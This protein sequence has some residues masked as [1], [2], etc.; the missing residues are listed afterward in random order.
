MRPRRT[1]WMTPDCVAHCSAPSPADSGLHRGL[2]L[3]AR[4]CNSAKGWPCATCADVFAVRVFVLRRTPCV[5]Y[6]LQWKQPSETTAPHLGRSMWY[7]AGASDG[8]S[9]ARSRIRPTT[10]GILWPRCRN[11]SRRR[12][13]KPKLNRHIP[14]SIANPCATQVQTTSLRMPVSQREPRNNVDTEAKAK[15]RIRRQLGHHGGV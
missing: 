15:R 9:H 7:M 8:Q 12:P 3:Q 10:V 1:P 4:A 5:Q 6:A 11:L 13:H 2:Q 14:E